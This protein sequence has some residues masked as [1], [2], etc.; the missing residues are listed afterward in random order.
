MNGPIV[1]DGC[2]S[3]AERLPEHALGIHS[4]A[5]RADVL[6]HQDR[7]ASCR[8][9]LESWAATADALPLLLGEAEPPSGFEGRTMD[10]LRTEQALEPR[11]PIWRRVLG[12]AAIVAMAMI[13]T[14]AGVR[15]V[16][17]GNGGSS[18]NVAE[19]EMTSAQ[20]VGRGGHR[21]GDA[22]MTGGDDRYVFVDVDYG[23]GSG[24]Y[25]IETVDQANHSTRIGAVDVKEGH[26][27][28]AGELPKGS[29]DPQMLRMI[30][31]DGK[32]FCWA[33]FGP[34]AT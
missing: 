5:E 26:G 17:A 22:F 23:V 1:P 33:K 8:A 31:A 27:A 10:R 24:R 18:R 21:A 32:V 15:L 34:I 19:T 12:V 7:S 25:D 28:W 4:G 9:E 6:A 2:A 16:D 13:V 29:A 14:L 3:M 20:M 11:W 30:D